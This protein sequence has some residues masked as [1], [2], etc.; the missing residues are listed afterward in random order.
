VI[1][2]GKRVA[3]GVHGA[4]PSFAPSRLDANGNLRGG[5][6]FESVYAELIDRHLGGDSRAVLGGAFAHVGALR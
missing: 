6:A 2:L 3:G 1:L 5:I 4:Q